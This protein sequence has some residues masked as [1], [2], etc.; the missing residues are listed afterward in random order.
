MPAVLLCIVLVPFS[1]FTVQMHDLRS[2]T[3]LWLLPISPAC[4]SANT[5]G[6]VA[7]AVPSERLGVSVAYLGMTSLGMGALLAYQI[8]AQYWHRLSC[9][10][11]PAREVRVV[12][13][14]VHVL[15]HSPAPV[16]PCCKL[17]AARALHPQPN[18]TRSL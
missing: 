8:I 11:L 1:M 2:M 9:Y 17:C 6:I 7:A 4:V 5:A 13:L 15:A 3:A 10:K 12:C 14:R 16:S 18:Q